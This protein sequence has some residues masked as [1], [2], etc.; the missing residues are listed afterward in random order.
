LIA[1]TT[2]REKRAYP[3]GKPTTDRFGGIAKVVVGVHDL[4][5]VI[6]Q[7]RK[8][9]KL[10][11]PLRQKDAKFGADLAWFEGTPVVLAQGSNGSWLSG[12]V[13]EYGDAPVAFILSTASGVAGSPSEW[14][15]KSVF[16][17][18]DAKLGWRLGFESF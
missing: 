16:W 17:T 3:G 14:F 10:A 11:A 7:Y 5:G 12:R 2:P 8:A 1:D 15:G 13:G 6:A 18:D 4:E 9:F